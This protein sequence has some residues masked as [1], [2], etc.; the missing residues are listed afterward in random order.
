MNTMIK[1]LFLAVLTAL[2]SSC[3]D[4]SRQQEVDTIVSSF[5]VKTDTIY[6]RVEAMNVRIVKLKPCKPI[7]LCR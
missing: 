2:I 3:G 4:N 1:A 5:Y 7:I 6:K